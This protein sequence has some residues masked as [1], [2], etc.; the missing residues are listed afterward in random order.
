M[1][2]S[3][4]LKTTKYIYKKKPGRK[5]KVSVS[6]SSFLRVQFFVVVIPFERATKIWLSLIV[7]IFFFYFLKVRRTD[8]PFLT[9]VV[10]PHPHGSSPFW[11]AALRPRLTGYVVAQNPRR[12]DPPVRTEEILEIVL[13]HVLRQ[14]ADV[15]IRPLD[16]FAARSRVRH[17]FWQTEIAKNKNNLNIEIFEL[18]RKKSIAEGKRCLH[19]LSSVDNSSVTHLDSFVLQSKSV[20]CVD[21][22]LGVLG[23]VVVDE[24]IAQALPCDHEVNG[25]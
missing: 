18:K 10:K 12:Y 14:T 6:F 15:K 25:V 17:L 23:P 19:S 13:R 21:G 7:F 1:T 22:F 11:P 3:T 5:C 4:N 20:Q 16:S 2:D 8:P 9:S 24:A